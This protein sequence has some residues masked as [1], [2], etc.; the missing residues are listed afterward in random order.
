MSKIDASFIHKG[1][2]YENNLQILTQK[3]QDFKLNKS[4]YWSLNAYESN[5]YI[6]YNPKEWNTFKITTD[7]DF[8][9]IEENLSSKEKKLENHFLQFS[10]RWFQK[11]GIK[12]TKAIEVINALK[13]N[14]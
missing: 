14:F 6:I 10:N 5:P 4:E 1:L 7:I 11:N 12:N 13:T 8:A 2:T 3:F 9:K